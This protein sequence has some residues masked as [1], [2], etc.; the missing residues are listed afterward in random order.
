MDLGVTGGLEDKHCYHINLVFW[1]DQDKGYL[2]LQ[3]K[4]TNFFLWDLAQ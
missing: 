3:D 2:C 1:E 4:N